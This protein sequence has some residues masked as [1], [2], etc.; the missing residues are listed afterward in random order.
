MRLYLKP[1]LYIKCGNPLGTTDAIL[2]TLGVIDTAKSGG[3]G[4]VNWLAPV[5]N[6][7]LSG[8]PGLSKEFWVSGCTISSTGSC[9]WEW[10]LKN[11]IAAVSFNG[12]SGLVNGPYTVFFTSKVSSSLSPYNSR[13]FLSWNPTGILIWSD[14]KPTPLF[15]PRDYI[16]SFPTWG[17]W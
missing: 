4:T 9:S 7:V 14:P 10:G 15:I 3:K 12:L 17:N 2:E 5:L 8:S 1:S 13:L 16:S 6:L 11:D